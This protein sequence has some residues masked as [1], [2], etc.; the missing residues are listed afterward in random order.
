MLFKFALKYTNFCPKNHSDRYPCKMLYCRTQSCRHKELNQHEIYIDK[1]P[2]PWNCMQNYVY[3]CLYLCMCELKKKEAMRERERLKCPKGLKC[4][5]SFILFSSSPPFPV[6]SER[7]F[8]WKVRHYSSFN[9]GEKDERSLL[10][11]H[12]INVLGSSNVPQTS[13]ILLICYYF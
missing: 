1:I 8:H 2:D 7:Q 5:T 3:V 10:A 13:S 6:E 12:L 4:Q 11:S 9:V